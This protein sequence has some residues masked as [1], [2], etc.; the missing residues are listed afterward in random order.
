[1]VRREV[2][3]I[4]G[5]SVVLDRVKLLL[6]LLVCLFLLCILDMRAI[7]SPSYIKTFDCDNVCVCQPL[8]TCPFIFIS[9]MDTV[10][11]IQE[12]GDTKC[13]ILYPIQRIRAIFF[14]HK[15]HTYIYDNYN[16]AWSIISHHGAILLQ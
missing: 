11:H 15:E 5:G 12:G 10:K 9:R 3:T 7:V 8:L 4:N 2:D 14:V 6:S 1:M 13:F 16:A